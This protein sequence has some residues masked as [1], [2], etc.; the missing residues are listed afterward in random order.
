MALN[1]YSLQQAFEVIFF[2]H[3]TN[4]FLLGENP[5]RCL[6]SQKCH[7]WLKKKKEIQLKQQDQQQG[8]QHWSR[9]RWRQWGDVQNQALVPVTKTGGCS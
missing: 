3:E 6:C 5:C 7:L 8:K 9:C 2:G 4:P 1:P